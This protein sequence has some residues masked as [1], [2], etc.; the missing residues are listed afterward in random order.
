METKEHIGKFLVWLI[1][2]PYSMRHQKINGMDFLI[3]E[4]HSHCFK[5][6]QLG[7]HSSPISQPKRKGFDEIYME[8]NK[9][10]NEQSRT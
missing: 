1:Q 2:S 6:G 9:S 7:L 10:L 5:Q 8:F 3:F 4:D